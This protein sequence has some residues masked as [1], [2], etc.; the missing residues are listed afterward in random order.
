MPGIAPVPAPP[1]PPS[2]GF[3]SLHLTLLCSLD[4]G[5]IRNWGE[6]GFISWKWLSRTLA[7]DTG[8]IR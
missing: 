6:M 7:E 4:I 2:M 5:V 1:H 3:Q 8:V